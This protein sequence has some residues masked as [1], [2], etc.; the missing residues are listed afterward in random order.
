V[1]CAVRVGRSVWAAERDGCVVVRDAARLQPHFIEAATPCIRV[2]NPVRQGLQPRTLEAAALRA[3][4]GTPVCQVRDVKTAAAQHRIMVG[5]HH[6]VWCLLPLRQQVWC[7]TERGG[8]LIL[9]ATSR[10]VVAE[11]R[12]QP[13]VHAPATPQHA[14]ATPRARAC[15][16]TRTRPRP[17]ECRRAATTAASIASP[18]PSGLRASHGASATSSSQAVPTSPLSCGATLASCAG[19]TMATL[20]R[21]VRCSCSG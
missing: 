16:P 3:R 15:N 5:L 12:L 2:C 13:H 6:L 11:A 20:A 7:G 1:R 21:C 4:G 17:C 8:C 10:E 19:N 14:P 9:D 18:P